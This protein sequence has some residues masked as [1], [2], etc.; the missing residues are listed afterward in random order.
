M[1]IVKKVDKYLKEQRK[2]IMTFNLDIIIFQLNI[3][4]FAKRKYN[5]RNAYIQNHLIKLNEDDLV[6]YDNKIYLF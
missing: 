5:I 1:I 4:L 2:Q 3:D 6:E